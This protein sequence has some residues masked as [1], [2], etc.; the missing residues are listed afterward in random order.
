MALVTF[1]RYQTIT[2]DT[3]TPDYL[4]SARIEY[5]VELLEDE[6]GRP[7]ASAV[8]TE[9][10]WP[11]R[12]GRLWPKAIPVTDAGDYQ[13]DGAALYA[14]PFPQTF[15]FIEGTTSVAVTYT[16][17]WVERTANPVA[18]NRLP[19]CIE[20][21]LAFVAKALGAPGSG[22]L[23]GLPAGVKQASVGDVSVTF[24]GEPGAPSEA[25]IAWSTETLGYRYRRV[26]GVDDRPLHLAYGGWW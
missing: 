15:G 12:D 23:D 4:V 14:S 22:G 19:T 17:G 2:G 24:D 21:D 16:G 9:T 7:L 25:G 18:T 8:R 1:V 13:V 5:A 10:M 26:G 3:S 6:L 11:T 20:R